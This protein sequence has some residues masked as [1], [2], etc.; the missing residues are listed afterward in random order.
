[1]HILLITFVVFYM[2]TIY[3]NENGLIIIANRSVPVNKTLL[4]PDIKK[5]FL[6]K[7]L[8]WS[9]E[10]SIIVVNR[11]SGSEPRNKFEK[12]LDLSSKKYSLYL[13]KMHY[14]GVALPIIQGSKNA[15]LGFVSNVPGSIAYIE[16]P[17][18]SDSENIKVIGHLN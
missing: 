14:K 16:G 7:Q 10:K 15:V 13:R 5:I 1:M 12:K 8:T 17:L 6:L 4:M 11:K 3:A 18:P 9:D 2:Q